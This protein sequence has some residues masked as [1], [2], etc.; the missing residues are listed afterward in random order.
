MN[1]TRI[2]LLRWQGR[3]TVTSGSALP[4]AAAR[5]VD[6]AVNAED[7]AVGETETVWLAHGELDVEPY[8]V[9][10][11][12]AD[13]LVAMLMDADRDAYRAEAGRE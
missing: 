11:E 6:H 9:T 12:D 1:L 3:I 4:G 2:V 10:R 8:E 13:H 7:A 5:I